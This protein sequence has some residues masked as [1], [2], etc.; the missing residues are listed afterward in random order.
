MIGYAGIREEV[1]STPDI[2]EE[3]KKRG[4]MIVS[5]LSVGLCL[6]LTQAKVL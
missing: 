4:I 3:R 6:T 2:R 5:P 1:L